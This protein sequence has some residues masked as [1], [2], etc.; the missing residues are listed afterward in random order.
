MLLLIILMSVHTQDSFAED[1]ISADIG[2]K[3]VASEE[4]RSKETR[5]EE[6][7][8]EET[9]SE[10]IK[11][12]AT[13]ES[14]QESEVDPEA[15]AIEKY[16]YYKGVNAKNI[17]VFTYHK[18]VDKDRGRSSLVITKKALSRQLKY[19]YDNDY[20]TINCEEF[21]LWYKKKIK[22]PPKTV[23]ITFDDGHRGVV[24]YALPLLK[25]YDLKATTFIIGASTYNSKE[26]SIS[27]KQWRKL[28]DTQTNLEF[29]S[30][31]YALHR[32]DKV[33]SSYTRIKKDALRQKKVYGFEYLAYPFGINTAA[34][35]KAYAD[36]GIKLA[37]AYGS[38]GYA[39]RKQNIYQIKR[40][41][42]YGSSFDSFKKW[43]K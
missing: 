23:M 31:T 43:L 12:E 30:H 8:T 21:Y 5:T 41:K 38:E 1:R 9:K 13:S 37:F 35:R 42:V 6:A 32:R 18:V 22:L 39:T 19:L 34:M 16:G 33:N 10:E 25:K 27:Y 28:K 24:E 4:A 26:N 17:P 14:A 3:Q 20:R 2:C 40:V 11:S 36:T 15:E 29:Q 7:K